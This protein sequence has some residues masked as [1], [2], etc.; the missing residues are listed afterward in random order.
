MRGM[1][2]RTYILSSTG[3]VVKDHVKTFGEAIQ[4]EIVI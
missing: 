1:E 3:D 4:K 2:N